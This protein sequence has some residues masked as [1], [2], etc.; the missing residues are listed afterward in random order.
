MCYW[1]LAHIKHLLVLCDSEFQ[2]ISP[3]GLLREKATLHLPIFEI[4]NMNIVIIQ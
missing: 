1:E 3:A 4:L 2:K